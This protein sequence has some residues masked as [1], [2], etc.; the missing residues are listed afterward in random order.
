M[1][2]EFRWQMDLPQSLESSLAERAMEILKDVWDVVEKFRSGEI[3][4]GRSSYGEM[5]FPILDD[6]T[7]S[8][9]EI[10][11][12]LR[13]GDIWLV[14]PLEKQFDPYIEW[15]SESMYCKKKGEYWCRVLA[16]VVVRA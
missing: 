3:G 14:I 5:M 10:P 9:D 11:Y 6:K 15:M 2:F 4:C 12:R 8:R 1:R 13:D 7:V 16:E